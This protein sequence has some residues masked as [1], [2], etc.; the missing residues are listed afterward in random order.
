MIR[1]PLPEGPLPAEVVASLRENDVPDET[2]YLGQEL[3]SWA[4]DLTPRDRR[5]LAEL[6]VALLERRAVD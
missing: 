6:T 4:P 5:A 3:A 1:L 2:I